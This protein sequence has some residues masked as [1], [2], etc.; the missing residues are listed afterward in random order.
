[1]FGLD[2]GFV[3]KENSIAFYV[4]DNQNG[5]FATVRKQLQTVLDVEALHRSI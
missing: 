2:N 5:I 3:P 4:I 1:M